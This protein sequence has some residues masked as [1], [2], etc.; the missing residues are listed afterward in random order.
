VSPVP[1]RLG[2][3]RASRE[4]AR[5]MSRVKRDS[6]TYHQNP[7]WLSDHAC[8]CLA[9]VHHPP[10]GSQPATPS[11]SSPGVRVSKL[12]MRNRGPAPYHPRHR[13]KELRLRSLSAR[14]S[15]VWQH[16]LGRK[17][18]VFQAV[19][20]LTRERSDGGTKGSTGN[21]RRAHYVT[22]CQAKSSQSDK[23]IYV[24]IYQSTSTYVAICTAIH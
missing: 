19:C 22:I 15:H 21:Q 13:M 20:Y 23:R 9:F 18:T 11:S 17:R 12:T 10:S 8:R 7:L 16:M 5:E 1:L 4:R 3:E 6:Q 2:T 24:A 14:L